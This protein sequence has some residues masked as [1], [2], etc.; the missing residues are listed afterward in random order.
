MFC[1]DAPVSVVSGKVGDIDLL[2]VA[3]HGADDSVNAALLAELTPS[4][5]VI[6][7]GRNAY[8]HPSAN[9]LLLF[10]AAGAQVWRT[11]LHGAV[12]CRLKQEGG[13]V[14]RPYQ[15]P[16]VANGLE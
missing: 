13:V 1:G 3:H 5:A 14:V 15:A 7:V 2:K 6:P 9:T 16:E 11:D 8:A 12:S 10:E 4:V